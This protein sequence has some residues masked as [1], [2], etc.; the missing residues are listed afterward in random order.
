MYSEK[1]GA[2][3]GHMMGGG[4]HCNTTGVYNSLLTLHSFGS[5]EKKQRFA[6]YYLLVFVALPLSL[7]GSTQ[8]IQMPQ[9]STVEVN[10]TAFF[11]CEASFSPVFDVTYDWYHN[12]RKLDFIRIYSDGSYKVWVEK[13]PYF[14]RVHLVSHCFK[15]WTGF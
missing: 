2:R 11:R 4:E 6:K 10:S 12:N 14:E 13:E 15:V 8:L 7:T 1:R 9:D 5:P 3:G